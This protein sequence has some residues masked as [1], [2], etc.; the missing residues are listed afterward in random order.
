LYR[1]LAL[2]PYE[3]PFL[4]LDA[5]SAVVEDYP[6]GVNLEPLAEEIEVVLKWKRSV[7]C[8]HDFKVPGLPEFGHGSNDAYLKKH[9]HINLDVIK[10]TIKDREVRVFFP[11]LPQRLL[12]KGKIDWRKQFGLRGRVYL[13]VGPLNDIL[14][15]G[16]KTLKC[17]GILKEH[18]WT[19]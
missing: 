3:I 14:E 5:H 18:K 2:L 16:L 8:I 1:L 7:V 6:E 11:M 15:V 9:I 12:Q 13:I 10:E 17:F 4:F 19:E